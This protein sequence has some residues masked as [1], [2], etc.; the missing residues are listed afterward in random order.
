M[1]LDIL[2]AASEQWAS[3]PDASTTCAAS[4]SE[5]PDDHAGPTGECNP[6]PRPGPL[7]P[8]SRRKGSTMLINEKDL[9]ARLVKLH[10]DLAGKLDG[11][12]Y[13]EPSLHLYPGGTIHCRVYD[14]ATYNGGTGEALKVCRGETFN[15]VLSQAEAFV[16]SMPTPEIKARHDW[17]RKLG[18][19][20]DEG[21]ALALPD[22]VMAPIRAG[23]QAMAKN[24]LAAE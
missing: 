10:T 14:R 5:Q 4:P 9:N 11:Q 19:V 12:P 7:P 24:L 8:S 17:H 15:E 20:I 18:N 21:H 1:P 23:S 22:D 2:T 6:A 13:F 16:A 3:R